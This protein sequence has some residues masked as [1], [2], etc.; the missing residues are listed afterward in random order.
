VAS[1][2]PAPVAAA[3][4][5]E[6]RA[7][8]RSREPRRLA[9]LLLLLAALLFGRA[10][11]L[12]LDV[13]ARQQGP[14]AVP[15]WM[16]PLDDAYIFIRYAQQAARGRPFEW[17]PGEPSTGA[18]SLLYTA[19]LVPPHWFT[20]DLAA[21]ARWSRWVGIASLAALGLAGARALRAFDLPA[22]WPLAGG[23]CLVWS[24]P[25]GF[26]A[27]AGMESAFN[28]ALVLLACALWSEA[29][30][31]PV[32]LP[33]RHRVLALGVIAVLPLARPENAA[34]VLAA[35]AVLLLGRGPWPRWTALLLP[36]PGLAVGFLNR[37]FTG[38][39]QPAGA[40][41]KSWL[42]APFVP[43]A[44]L[45]RQVL[46]DA[47]E[48]LLPVYLGTAGPTLWPPVGGLALATAA[49]ALA[50]TAATAAARARRGAVPP[51][52]QLARIA[53][54]AAAWAV[55]VA[56]A[57]FS[58]VLEWQQM[59][60]HHAGLACAWL[61]AVAGTALLAEC[62]LAL[63]ASGRGA[64]MLRN[65]ALLLP[66]PLLFALPFW[67]REYTRV[68]AALHRTHGP[69]QAFL[70]A[71]HR[72]RPLLL[73]DA[74]LL[75]LAHDGPAVD[76]FGLGSPDLTRA[77]R[78]GPGALVEALARRRPLPE[79]AAVTR[80]LV[81]LPQLLGAPLLPAGVSP[82]GT[83][84]ARV[85]TDQ[86]GPTPLAGPGV[87]FASL[88]DEQ[89]AEV[90]WTLPPG[91]NQPSFALPAPGPALQGCR[92]LF[93]A[94]RLAVPAGVRTV[95]LTA[96]LL[97][98]GPGGVEVRA[99]SR[100]A[101]ADP[102]LGAVSLTRGPWAEVAAAWPAGRSHAWISRRGTGVPCLESLAFGR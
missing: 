38:E 82:D 9:G 97:T 34:L 101:P 21:A 47:R 8:R 56:V 22:P 49:G 48:I 19:L 28:A 18:S 77:Y 100:T 3:S 76:L 51:A 29:A 13:L 71:H 74:G 24:G 95:R 57:P 46:L 12:L 20:D 6:A 64:A 83:V 1:P 53:P 73:N 70:A 61:L 32:E 25:I 5:D 78:H 10:A 4:V 87:D 14:A 58:A 89:R 102:V 31:A 80:R 41:A 69:A 93:G 16:L 75:A 65:V 92:P 90:H 37:A 33:R 67:S 52:G 43:P 50:A 39:L 79:I 17:N 62:L 86:L 11:T 36:L 68:A 91:T 59:R 23:L 55:L 42:A 94:V 99:G 40:L 81:Q 66:V 85:R 72:D 54:L 63:R 84:V 26:A 2:P 98:D 35:A 88:P 7:V 44:T 96:T 45:L 27:L 60:H 30:R 15:A